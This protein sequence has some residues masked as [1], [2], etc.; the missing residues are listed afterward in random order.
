MHVNHR[1]LKISHWWSVPPDK[2]KTMIESIT[3]PGEDAY[4]FDVGGSWISCYLHGVV[5]TSKESDDDT[6]PMRSQTTLAYEDR[7]HYCF[8]VNRAMRFMTGSDFQRLLEFFGYYWVDESG[9]RKADDAQVELD[10][11]VTFFDMFNGFEFHS[12]EGFKKFYDHFRFSEVFRWKEDLPIW[13]IHER[14]G[15]LLRSYVPVRLNLYDG[16]HRMLLMALF[17]TGYLTPSN[18]MPLQQVDW[19]Q[20][21]FAD[22]DYSKMQTFEKLFYA[23]GMPTTEAR[24]L[25]PPEA[26][27]KM[28]CKYLHHAG[29]LIT[30]GASNQMMACWDEFFTKLNQTTQS[31]YTRL[32]FGNYWGRMSSCAAFDENAKVLFG[33]IRDLLAAQG[34]FLSLFLSATQNKATF[35]QEL[36]P[37]LDSY[38]NLGGNTRIIVEA[39]EILQ[40]FRCVMHSAHGRQTFLSF[41][42]SV[43]STHPQRSSRID[44]YLARFQS[45]EWL[46]KYVYSVAE[47]VVDHCLQRYTLERHLVTLLRTSHADPK[48][49]NG[50]PKLEWKADDID[51]WPSSRCRVKDFSVAGIRKRFSMN[52]KGGFVHD[53]V[54]FGLWCGVVQDI[55]ESIAKYGMDPDFFYLEVAARND[56]QTSKDFRDMFTARYD[57]AREEIIT[58]YEKEGFILDTTNGKT[59]SSSTLMYKYVECDEDDSDGE[60]DDDDEEEEEDE[61][62]SDEDLQQPKKKK[63]KKDTTPARK[64]KKKYYNIYFDIQEAVIKSA[65]TEQEKM[66]LEGQYKNCLLREYLRYVEKLPVLCQCQFSYTPHFCRYLFLKPDPIGLNSFR[67]TIMVATLPNRTRGP[68]NSQLKSSFSFMLTTFWTFIL[69]SIVG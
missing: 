51:K 45:A 39:R 24:G 9:N 52:T 22:L 65:T 34:R 54:L 60:E 68:R 35:L 40:L 62:E 43:T 18:R 61:N 37:A 17:L 1:D 13:V 64:R 36:E 44:G 47:K 30:E 21:Q 5:D 14:F 15:I 27:F 25:G 8:A 69:C 66:Q 19:S 58:K 7:T 59:E 11:L 50:L 2:Q 38:S 48:L 31:K 63:R 20:S 41:F 46:R 6:I 32:V 33:G 42:Q 28:A 49:K 4:I 16:Q 56:S 29:N 10:D 12:V 55:F 26:N 53:R 23:V 3:D 57:T 67:I